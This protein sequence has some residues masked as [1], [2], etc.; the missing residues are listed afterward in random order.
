M[1]PEAVAAF[2][3]DFAELSNSQGAEQAQERLRLET[4]RKALKRKLEG[5]YDAIAEALRSPGLGEKLLNL[6]TCVIP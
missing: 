3:K 1:E 4:E 6:E 5:L 2:V